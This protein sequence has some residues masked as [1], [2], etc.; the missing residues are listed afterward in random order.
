[1]CL[2]TAQASLFIL[3]PVQESQE[4]LRGGW[5]TAISLAQLGW[6]EVMIKNSR[7]WAARRSLVQT[8]QVHG[9]EEWRV[10][11]SRDFA[12]GHTQAQEASRR[13][14]QELEA[15]RWQKVGA[16]CAQELFVTL[17]SSHKT[18]SDCRISGSGWQHA[19]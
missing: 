9:E 3:C 13:V 2:A 14:K 7:E 15:S 11:T 19:G 17:T 8:N 5:H 4:W 6:T 10:P 1:M 16:A 12:Y 18:F